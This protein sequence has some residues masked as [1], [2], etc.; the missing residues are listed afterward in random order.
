MDHLEAI[1]EIKNIV[2][3][4]F[5]NKLISL[6]ENKAKKNL[7]VVSGINKVFRNVKGHD[8]RRK[9]STDIFYW[10]YIAKEIERLFLFYKI[11]FP[12]ISATTI[13]QINL[14][15]YNVGGK[16]MIHIDH[17]TTSNREISVIIN[18]ND[19]YEGGDLIFT[20]QKEKEIKRL[21]LEKNSIIFFPSNFLYPHGIEPITK[22]NRYSIVTWIA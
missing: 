10:D 8:L 17:I 22:G 13:N 1:V 6:I 2:S 4:E 14:L 21:K 7:P 3:P 18:L 19:S 9:N 12:L 20:D 5:S 16:H 11:K 15:K